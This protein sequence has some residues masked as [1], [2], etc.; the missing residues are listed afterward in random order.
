MM[1]TAQELINHCKAVS[2]WK[3]VYGCKGEILTKDKYNR[4]K[5]QYG[6]MVWDSDI[7][8]LGY[9]C[10]DCSG[11]ISSCTG[12]QRGSYNYKE[13]AVEVLPVSALN[14]NWDNYV[15]WAI[16]MQ[17]HIGVVSDT[18]GYYYA[19]DGSGRNWVH[20][21]LNKQK[22]THILKL[23]DI[24]Y[25]IT[26]WIQS[27]GMWYYY[28][29]GKQ[30]KGDWIKDKGKWFHLSDNGYMDTNAWIHNQS[31]TWSYVD[32]T[33]EAVTG[34]N[35]LEWNGTI[36]WYYFDEEG[37]MLRDTWIYD[38]YVGHSGA[39]I[40]ESWITWNGRYYWVG[41]NGKWFDKNGWTSFYRPED[42]YPIYE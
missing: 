31:G 5:K 27:D 21:P 2:D 3:Y 37:T 18:K 1:K 32:A 15:G 17:G 6:S 34:W 19:M 35:E 28:R 25:P 20:N 33:G 13:T 7:N 23:K 4:L 22:F 38:Y 41:A 9:M 12:I 24:E 40:K 30:L 29:A 16:W 39:L 42:G 26:G 11:L 36:S 8:K 14:A 10:C